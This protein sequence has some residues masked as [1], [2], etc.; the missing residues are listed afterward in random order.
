VDVW[1]RGGGA[2]RQGAFLLIPIRFLNT[3]IL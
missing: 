1:P 3:D 2:A